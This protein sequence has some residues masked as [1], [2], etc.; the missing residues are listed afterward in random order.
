MKF[1]MA[2]HQR[3]QANSVQII[4]SLRKTLHLRG[5]GVAHRG[6]RLVGPR[7]DTFCAEPA[8]S[9]P[10]PAGRALLRPENQLAVIG[11]V[12]FDVSLR[13]EELLDYVSDTCL[14]GNSIRIHKGEETN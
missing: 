13:Q 10:P 11:A 2:Q 14:E 12:R 6:V 8:P 7:T 1:K 3:A 4:P 9:H 5:V